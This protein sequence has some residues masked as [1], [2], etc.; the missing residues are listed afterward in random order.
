MLTWREIL[1]SRTLR[2]QDTTR[3]AHV[4]T[5][6]NVTV[7]GRLDRQP[8]EAHGLGADFVVMPRAALLNSA[9]SISI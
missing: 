1:D 8:L 6:K 9:Y 3:A 2:N 5:T 4:Q 7:D